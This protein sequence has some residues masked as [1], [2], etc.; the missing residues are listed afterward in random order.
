MHTCRCNTYPVGGINI[1]RAN[2]CYSSVSATIAGCLSSTVVPNGAHTSTAWLWGFRFVKCIHKV[3]V[4]GI[5][6]TENLFLGLCM[7]SVTWT[8]MTEAKLQFVQLVCSLRPWWSSLQWPVG[9][10]RWTLL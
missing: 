7:F 6:S 5:T 4:F 1:N 3:A 10:R 8:V 2:W 9:S